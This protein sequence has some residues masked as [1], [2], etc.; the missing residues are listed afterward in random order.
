MRLFGLGAGPGGDLRDCVPRTS[1]TRWVYKSGE[2]EACI[3]VPSPG[4]G[5]LVG[6]LPGCFLLQV[7]TNS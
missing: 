7:F 4:L 3:Q 6:S 2:G 1:R 5:E